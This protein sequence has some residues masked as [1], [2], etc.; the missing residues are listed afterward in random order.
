M[1][2]KYKVANYHM[3]WLKYLG[4]CLFAMNHIHF[5]DC[6]GH[7]EMYPGSNIVILN[8]PAT[9]LMTQHLEDTH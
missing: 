7:P 5:V 9:Y 2:Q 8:H 3:F 1:N 6:S 4:V